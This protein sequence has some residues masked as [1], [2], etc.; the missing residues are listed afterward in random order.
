MRFHDAFG[1]EQLEA[2]AAA[3]VLRD[4]PEPLED[5]L[6]LVSCDTCSRVRH[7]E[8]D[9]SSYRLCAKENPS[10]LAGEFDRVAEK[11]G[12]HL[13]HAFVIEHLRGLL[14]QRWLE[15]GRPDLLLPIL[16]PELEDLRRT[17][18]RSALTAARQRQWAQALA[19][20]GVKCRGFFS[21][22][23]AL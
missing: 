20:L 22:L 12:Q 2:E 4:L 21:M 15:R 3:I 8:D 13:K 17:L 5:G 16:P 19:A 14:E 7:R 18:P 11:V 1:N 23:P 6:Q 9:F 10:A